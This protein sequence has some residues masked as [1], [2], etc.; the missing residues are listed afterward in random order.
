MLFDDVLTDDLISQ[1][2]TIASIISSN[3]KPSFLLS[4][5]VYQKIT[6][7]EDEKWLLRA[8]DAS[9]KFFKQD[10]AKNGSLR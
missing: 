6:D 2:S 9:L 3:T 4:D 5:K 10:L 8:C 1:N 7:S